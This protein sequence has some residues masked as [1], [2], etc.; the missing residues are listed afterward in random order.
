ML[1]KPGR[2]REENRPSAWQRRE[3][4]RILRPE[5]LD[6]QRAR[7][8]DEEGEED[9]FAAEHKGCLLGRA[10]DARRERGHYR[11][12]CLSRSAEGRKGGGSRVKDTEARNAVKKVRLGGRPPTKGGPKLEPHPALKRT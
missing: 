2:P 11:G 9:G 1:F 7:V 6:I 3:E 4:E 5:E 12:R 10:P 8:Q